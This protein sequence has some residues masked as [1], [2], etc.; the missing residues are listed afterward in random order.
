MKSY[1]KEITPGS[2]LEGKYVYFPCCYSKSESVYDSIS[3]R[4][5]AGLCTLSYYDC[6]IEVL[7]VVHEG[8][9][10]T[11]PA[12]QVIYEVPACLHRSVEV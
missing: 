4:S 1:L 10:A 7:N 12:S 6:G 11:V 5:I 9:Y 3:N 2:R 8:T